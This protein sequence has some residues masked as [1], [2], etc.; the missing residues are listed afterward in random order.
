MLFKYG[1]AVDAMK[2]SLA[3]AVARVTNEP[4]GDHDNM[5]FAYSRTIE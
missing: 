5:D 2:T 4:T 3:T 1:S